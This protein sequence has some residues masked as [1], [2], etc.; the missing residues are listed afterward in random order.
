M[1]NGI[2]F[3]VLSGFRG[4]DY[5]SARNYLDRAV[6]MEP[7]NAE[8]RRA[9]DSLNARSTRSYHTYDNGDTGATVNTAMQL[10]FDFALCGFLLRMHGRRSDFL[11]LIFCFFSRFWGFAIAL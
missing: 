9:R 2:I 5:S 8:Y 11:L 10:L 1:R 7:G 4:G 3:M 6:S